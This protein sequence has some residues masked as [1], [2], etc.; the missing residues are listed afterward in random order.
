[1]DSVQ[2]APTLNAPTLSAP[3]RARALQPLLDRHGV[4]ID[5]RRELTPDVVD[6]LIAQDML[7]L[8]LPRSLGG[9]ELPLIDFCEAV[10][11]I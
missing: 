11:A 5:R 8:L 4:E 1:M 6:G 3:E 7:R 10:E 9:Q 2:P